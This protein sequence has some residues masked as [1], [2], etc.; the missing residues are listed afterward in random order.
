MQVVRRVADSPPAP[1]RARF[2]WEEQLRN[3]G[4]QISLMVPCFNEEEN[5]VG[6][7][8]NIRTA[9]NTLGLAYEVI[10]IDDCSTDRTSDKVKAYQDQY[11]E[12]RIYLHRNETNRGLARNFVDG[13][14]M[15]R[16][17]YYRM[18]CGDN[19]EPAEALINVLSHMGK[20]DLI[21]PFTEEQPAGK[22][23]P[24]QIL[25]RAFV[26]IV[27]LCSG[28]DIRYYNGLAIYRTFDVLRMHTQSRGFGF[29]AEIITRMLD[30][31]ATYEQI[32]SIS[33]ERSA[34]K[35]KAI[36]VHNWL[37]TG[38]A[39]VRIFLNRLRRDVFGR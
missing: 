25:S 2:P 20:A 28:Y 12:M 11:P 15:A 18:V 21:I 10:V 6:T 14:F 17:W 29:Q 24:R 38:Y 30:D 13:A 35:S 3:S 5:V 33:T 1:V 4:I 31:G 32:P 8:N 37:S 9:V 7:L 36:T 22:S 26:K 23:V 16:G 19:V 34:G 39:I 27:N